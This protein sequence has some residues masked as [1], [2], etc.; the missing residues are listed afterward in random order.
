MKRERTNLT[1]FQIFLA[2]E[3]DY[4]ARENVYIPKCVINKNL[5]ENHFSKKELYN[6]FI[7][8]NN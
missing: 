3:Y 6:H 2:K 4:N 5:R 8:T 1:P 7:K